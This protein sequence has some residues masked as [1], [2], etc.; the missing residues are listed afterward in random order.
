MPTPARPRWM[1]NSGPGPI[2]TPR[3]LLAELRADRGDAP[4]EPELPVD[5][6]RSAPCPV[7]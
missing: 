6:Q 5:E 1:S 4:A 3:E 2:E 7:S